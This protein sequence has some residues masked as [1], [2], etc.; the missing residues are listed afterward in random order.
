MYVGHPANTRA[1]SSQPGSVLPHGLHRGGGG[2]EAD[3]RMPTAVGS[4]S[5]ASV[6]MRSTAS[7]RRVHGSVVAEG[8]GVPVDALN[9]QTFRR[10][11]RAGSQPMSAV[12]LKPAIKPSARWRLDGRN[13]VEKRE[14]KA[15]PAPTA[16]AA[17]Q[18]STLTRR[19]AATGRRLPVNR[20]KRRTAC[21][22]VPDPQDRRLQRLVFADL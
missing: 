9:E 17:H 16:I 22:S 3:L 5:G 19:K 21:K 11:Q 15:R 6:H 4:A 18:T 12:P 2:V 14:F 8:S 20:C 7:W 13:V 10:P 1:P